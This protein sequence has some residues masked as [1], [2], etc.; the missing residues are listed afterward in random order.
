MNNTQTKPDSALLVTSVLEGK[1]CE[2]NEALPGTSP[3]SLRTRFF[4]FSC[5]HITRIR[6]TGM[7]GRNA[8]SCIH[9]IPVSTWS[10]VQFTTR[11]CLPEARNGISN[12]PGYR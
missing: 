6:E 10:N 11:I 2:S 8:P 5:F 3:S 12:C 9:N 7:A 4:I 1:A